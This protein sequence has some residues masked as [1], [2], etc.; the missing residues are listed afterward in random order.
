MKACPVFPA[1]A[2]LPA[3]KPSPGT[4]SRVQLPSQRPPTHTR[5]RP[6]QPS[7]VHVGPQVLGGVVVDHQLHGPHVDA[8]GRGVC[9]DEAVGRGAVGPAMA[10]SQDTPLPPAGDQADPG[11]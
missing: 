2:V 1:R 8:A 4:S 5:A 3:L 11:G 9:A 7:P 10:R 6:S